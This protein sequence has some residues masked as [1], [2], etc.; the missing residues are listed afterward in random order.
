MGT[1]SYPGTQE[2]RIGG[3]PYWILVKEVRVGEKITYPGRDRVPQAAPEN[4]PRNI[5]KFLYQTNFLDNLH[6]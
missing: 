1:L 5:I 3:V 4:N 2:G 6:L